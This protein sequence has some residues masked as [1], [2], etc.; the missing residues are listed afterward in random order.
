MVSKVYGVDGSET[1]KIE[2]ADEVFNSKVST[3]SIYHALRNELA[4]RRLGTASTKTRNAVRG[5]NA[6][7]W[8]QKGTGRARAGHKR[9]PL[10]V[11]GGTIF[12]PHPRDYSYRLPK[13]VKRLAFRSLLS[14]KLQE[15]RLMVVEDFA[16]DSGKTKEL[17]GIL[18]AFRQD[19]SSRTVVV[20]A[21]E[22]AMLKRAGR[23]L[24]GV[25]V[26]SYNRLRAH[27]LFYAGHVL[28]L[29]NAAVKLNG[30][31]A[32]DA[33]AKAAAS[34]AEP[35][36]RLPGTSAPAAGATPRKPTP[37]AKPAKTGQAPKG[38]ASRAGTAAGKKVTEPAKPTKAA[39]PSKATK[40]AKTAGTGAGRGTKTA[41]P[42]EAS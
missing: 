10:W 35:P 16:V 24:P 12:G 31:Y 36:M 26:L 41:A 8:K 33:V 14:Q 37:E 27:E 34:A 32:S 30:F 29:R 21:G 38:T 20:V 9:S 15:S 40:P 17:V 1:G 22:D 3:G 7:P 13:K 42:K 23:N 19:A 4:N 2:L 18:K 6:K 28:V 11:G 25:S 5:S 39:T